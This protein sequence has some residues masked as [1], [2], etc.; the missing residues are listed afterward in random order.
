MAFIDRAHSR[1]I[2]VILD[3]VPAHFVK[4]EAGLRRF[5]GSPLFESRDPLR[6]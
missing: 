2:G 3:W 6:A 1:N 5:D 4:D